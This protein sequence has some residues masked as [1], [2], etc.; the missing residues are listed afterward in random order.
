MDFPLGWPVIPAASVRR[1]RPLA[2]ATALVSVGEQVRPDQAV[3][4][5]PGSGGERVPVLAGLAGRVTEVVAGRALTLE[6]AA[7]VIQGLCGL[8]LPTV[9]PLHFLPRGE[10]LAV[11]PIPPGAII[12]FPGRLPLTLLQRAAAGGAAGIIAASVAAREL[13]AFVRADLSAVLDGL[14]PEV[15]RL[16][17]TLLFTEGVGS[18][19]MDP[20]M[21]QLL[22]QRA[23]DVALLHGFTNPRQN[24]RP[25]VLLPLPLGSATVATPLDDALVVGARTRVIAGQWRGGRGEV[26]HRFARSQPATPGLLV[27]AARVRLEDGSSP[28][29]PLAFLE[30]T[31]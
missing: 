8:G 23:G 24:I 4:H 6:G 5:L 13:E 20:I 17:I 15:A 19:A 3:A 16:P 9:G 26:I 25:E 28:I 21:F 11:V 2:G 12:V 29:V 1:Q 18:F 22:T 14:A 7:T 31:G 27:K 30:R 10:S